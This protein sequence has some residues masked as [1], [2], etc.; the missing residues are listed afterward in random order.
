MEA[1]N[2]EIKDVAT[3][4]MKREGKKPKPKYAILDDDKERNRDK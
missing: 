4:L 1:C 3:E 2:I